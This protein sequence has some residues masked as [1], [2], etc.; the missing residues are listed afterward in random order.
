MALT[1]SFGGKDARGRKLGARSVATYVISDWRQVRA[2]AECMVYR[3]SLRTFAV[4]LLWA[5]I[6]GFFLWGLCSYMGWP[7]EGNRYEIRDGE[8]RT[9]GSRELSPEAQQQK[10]ELDAAAESLREDFEAKY[11]P[12]DIPERTRKVDPRKAM[13]RYA[14]LM[15]G[16]AGYWV[17]VTLLTCGV[18]LPPLTCTWN[19]VTIR[20]N[21]RNEVVV[22]K[23]GLWPS[24]RRWPADTF[25]VIGIETREVFGYTE[26]GGEIFEGWRWKVQLLDRAHG[27]EDLNTPT[28][29][30][31]HQHAA[32]FWVH[33]EMQRG[34]DKH[35]PERVRVFV[36]GLHALTGLHARKPIILESERVNRG[37][38][39]GRRRHY[40]QAGMPH[41]STTATQ[42]TY[43][44]LDDVPE[45]L[46][47]QVEQ[48]M[49]E[50]EAS[51]DKTARRV[52][53]KRKITYRDR[54]GTMH[55]YDSPEDMPPELRTKFEA[56]RKKRGEG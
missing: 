14:L 46:R 54:H 35:L 11:G 38:F 6:F 32:E 48:L 33:Q 47:G 9:T 50:A 19:R 42:T 44:N 23:W 53:E 13:A 21:I 51:P 7:W 10:A 1:I 29:I 39:R 17:L 24:T 37:L 52:V 8:V 15:A 30:H 36:E 26:H 56:M 43:E 4:R 27:V 49:A 41:S 20:R 45:H 2:S 28:S 25:A 55:T 3:P 40:K 31:H 12:L 18:V 34:M 5:G 16:R 22:T